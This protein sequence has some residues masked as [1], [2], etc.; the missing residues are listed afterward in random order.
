MLL[1]RCPVPPKHN[2]RNLRSRGAHPRGHPGPLQ[3]AELCGTWHLQ[4]RIRHRIRTEPVFSTGR[5]RGGRKS[6]GTVRVRGT[7]WS[8]E[9][10]GVHCWR[11]RVPHSQDA[12]TRARHETQGCGQ[13]S[14]AI[15]RTLASLHTHQ[16]CR[17]FG[18]IKVWAPTNLE[19]YFINDLSVYAQR[20][21][22]MDWALLGIASS[23]VITPHVVLQRRDGVCLH[24]QWDVSYCT[25]SVNI[26]H[27]GNGS[28]L[29]L[30]TFTPRISAPLTNLCAITYLSQSVST[31][32]EDFITELVST[33]F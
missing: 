4:I 32:S 2:R 13:S 8:T 33:I 1:R 10:G 11:A 19:D 14:D 3:P 25:T 22:C 7:L 9:G 6:G 28:P 16:L 18:W 15:R 27:S 20:P 12:D 17:E 30:C 24:I 31:Y 26:T 21:E 5:E 29:S 23:W